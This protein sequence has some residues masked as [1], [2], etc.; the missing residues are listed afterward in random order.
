MDVST[1]L[2]KNKSELFH[3]T[4][5]IGL[6]TCKRSRPDIHYTVAVI[7]TRVKQPNTG[8]WKKLLRLMK[9]LIE[10]QYKWSKIVCRR[11]I[12][13]AFIFKIAY[14]ININN[15]NSRNCICVTK[16]KNEYKNQHGIRVNTCRLRVKSNIMD[17]V[18][19]GEK[20][21]KV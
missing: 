16:S 12:H 5:D 17:Q 14:R 19:L 3:T 13:S 9:S 7:C 1:D 6:L 21:Y 11:C 2:N 15:G 10:T 20:L 4:V 18:F 8:Y